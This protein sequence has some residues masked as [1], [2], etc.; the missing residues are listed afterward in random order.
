MIR[1]KVFLILSLGVPVMCNAD[2]VIDSCRDV[3]YA[4]EPVCFVS[5][6]RL[7]SRPMDYDG[8]LVVFSSV[9]RVKLAPPHSLYFS[10][11]ASDRQDEI[12]S[13]L[14]NFSDE[15]IDSS[16]LP[17]RGWVRVHGRFHVNRGD[18]ASAALATID[19]VVKIFAETQ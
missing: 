8:K 5:H 18:A 10:K 7:I 15:E 19:P 9:I 12:D 6:L 14:L 16:S 4:D 1:N 2:A 3:V 11:E 13:I 17:N